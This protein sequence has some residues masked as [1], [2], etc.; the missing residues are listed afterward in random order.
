M[1]QPNA[2]QTVTPD[3]LPFALE[4]QDGITILS[5][6]CFDT[7]LWRD[8]HAP[9][10]LFGMLTAVNP[11]QRMRAEGTAR[12]ARALA[13][14]A[15]NEVTLREIY[16]AALPAADDAVVERAVA[17]EIA[18][19]ARHCYGFAPT[20][21]LMREAKRRGLQIVIVSDTYLERD[22]LEGLIRAAAGDEV[23]DMIDRIF[24]SSEYRRAKTQGLFEDVLRATAARPDSILHIGDNPNADAIAA[25]QH[26][27]KWRHLVQ[28]TPATLQRM[29]YETA[30][31]RIG[32]PEAVTFLPH[33]AALAIGEPQIEDPAEALGFAVVGPVLAHFADWI[34]DEADALAATRPGKVHT[35]FLMRDGYLP[36]AVFG[37]RHP[38]RESAALDIS[39]FT[40]IAA[41]L[42]RRE[43]LDAYIDA[44][45]DHKVGEHFL[46]Q[47]LIK[48][49]EIPGILKALPSKMRGH[50]LAET[51]RSDRWA[52]KIV[53]RGEKF[54]K[55][56][57]AH[58]RSVV[59]PTPGDTI[60]L[61]D[62]G[63][64]GS[65][66]DRIEPL[67]KETFGVHVAG[68]Y[69]VL[70]EEWKSGLDKRGVISHARYGD[71]LLK[72]LLRSVAVFEQMCT[73]PYG[74]VIGY[75]ADGTPVRATEG[76]KGRQREMRDKVQTGCLSF[77]RAEPNATQRPSNP[78][79]AETRDHATMSILTRFLTMP[80]P[81]EVAMLDGF[82]HDGNLGG[83][84][85][86]PLFDPAVAAS[87]LRERGL[88]YLRDAER[89]YLP[90]ELSGQGMATTL[91]HLAFRRFDLGFIYGDF[92]DSKIELPLLVADGTEAFHDTVVA[93]PTHEGFYT[94]AV[95]VGAGRFSI[96]LAFGRLYEWVQIESI[97]FV[98][99]QAYFAH[100][101]LFDHL[102]VPAQPSCEGIEQVGPHL[103][104]CDEP[105]GF[106]MVPPP[107]D[108]AKRN[109]TLLVTFRP[110]TPRAPAQHTPLQTPLNNEVTTR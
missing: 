20:I 39:R 94:A 30:A 62:L 84:Y 79:Q 66:Q 105:E 45:V 43:N 100:G 91:T 59:A 29:R 57:L 14:R 15:S 104:R 19:E 23:V 21:A 4:G 103:Y 90:A 1:N 106:L 87:G 80:L 40:S 34:A 41:S 98:P 51:L 72:T 75:K 96:G 89:M 61:V 54:A 76:I 48:D 35:L 18:L 25:G 22:Q 78:A 17:E 108:A 81:H 77:A 42:G 6:D 88:F 7:L 55:H 24:C 97:R 63:Y 26:G 58:V 85:L 33:R 99:T 67:L 32:R 16:R 68:R 95:P 38:E 102:A 13:T 109:M 60:M 110:L 5:L 10:D 82:Q 71:G 70:R 101:A 44:Y 65:I 46:R 9:V 73:A 92:C 56:L 28:F 47:L 50:M 11:D 27:L 36:R 83:D 49:G 93:S 86:A 107:Q 64:G 31:G 52:S 12:K 8:V 3:R 69:L 74:S 37:A 53:A 2:T